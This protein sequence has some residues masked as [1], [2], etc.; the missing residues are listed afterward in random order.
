MEDQLL[1]T[2]MIGIIVAEKYC[3]N[4]KEPKMTIITINKNKK[5]L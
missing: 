4:M 2:T 1:I 3:S 5:I